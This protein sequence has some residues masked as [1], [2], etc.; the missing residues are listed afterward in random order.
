[1]LIIFSMLGSIPICFIIFWP[2]K[3]F[4]TKH[5]HPP[6]WTSGPYLKCK[7]SL[8]LVLMTYKCYKK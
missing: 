2:R 4:Q 1:M 6:A 5:R 8:L 3:L 7:S